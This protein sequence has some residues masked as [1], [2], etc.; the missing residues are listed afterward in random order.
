MTKPVPWISLAEAAQKMGIAKPHNARLRL[1]RL[2]E[3]SGE[4]IL[5]RNGS[6]WEVSPAAMLRAMTDRTEQ[7]GALEHRVTRLERRIFK[8][9]RA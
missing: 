7:L 3:S 6:R 5:R 4:R 9:A 8:R 1:Q 2:E